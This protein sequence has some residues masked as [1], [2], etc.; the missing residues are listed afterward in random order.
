MLV[1]TVSLGHVFVPSPGCCVCGANEPDQES[2]GKGQDREDPV[3]PGR[4][5][6]HQITLTIDPI[7]FPQKKKHV[8]GV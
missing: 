2:I 7:Y 5:T 3:V 4:S 6:R 8:Q 1:S